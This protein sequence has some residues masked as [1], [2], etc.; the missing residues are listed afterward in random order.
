M[1][2]Q[3]QVVAASDSRYHGWLTSLNHD[4]RIPCILGR[5]GMALKKSEGD[6]ITPIGNW[7]LRKIFYR[8]DRLSLPVTLLP[9]QAIAA[10]DG[11]CDDPAHPLYNQLVK[12]PFAAGH[13]DM[14]REDGAYDL[15]VVLGF[16]DQPVT[17]HAGSAIF[18][19]LA[20]PDWR[21]TAGCIAID[22]DTMLWLLAQCHPG[23]MMQIGTLDKES[24]DR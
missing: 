11:W 21:P 7:A 16:N 8:P 14:W 12:K 5:G 1:I 9:T 4:F 2:D 23:T 20:K 17:S 24:S 3:F 18:W 6:G 22:R 19:H 15:V 10:D 13:E